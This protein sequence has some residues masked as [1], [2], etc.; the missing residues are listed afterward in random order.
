MPSSFSYHGYLHHAGGKP[1]VY[2]NS[3]WSEGTIVGVHLDRWRGTLEFYLNRKSLGVAFTNI[4]PHLEVGR[5][6]TRVARLVLLQHTKTGK[7]IPI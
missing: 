5:I 4:L 7:N 3:K 1:R 6:P 2:A